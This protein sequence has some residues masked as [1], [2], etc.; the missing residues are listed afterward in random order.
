MFTTAG[1]PQLSAIRNFERQCLCIS[2]C[3][4]HLVERLVRSVMSSLLGLRCLEFHNLCPACSRLR[5]RAIMKLGK[6]WRRPDWNHVR[7]AKGGC[8]YAN[9]NH[10]RTV[11]GTST[12]TREK[13]ACR[14][15]RRLS[16][17]AITC[18]QPGAAVS[19]RE[20]Q[21]YADSQ[22]RRLS[23]R[24]PESY[25]DSRGRLSLRKSV[26]DGL[27]TNNGLRHPHYDLPPRSCSLERWALLRRPR[28]SGR[29]LARGCGARTT[30][31]PGT[32][33][34]RRRTASSFPRKSC[35]LPIAAGPGRSK[36]GG[37]SRRISGHRLGIAAQRASGVG[38][39]AGESSS[40]P[41]A[42]EN[43]DALV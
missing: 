4:R 26:L 16:L 37:L 12:P 6:T 38:R 10:M 2:I 32:H 31:P 24:K 14:G 5:V 17:T 13:R 20:R 25:E 43:T 19:L 21:S 7:T 41:A 9:R 3:I 22:G 30:I 35:R 18:G 29:R 27:G 23:L 28:S 40:C 42:A 36:P 1:P 33:P 15:P 8:P 11:G 39:H 34:N